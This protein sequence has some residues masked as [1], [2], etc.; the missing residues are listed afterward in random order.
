MMCQDEVLPVVET[1]TTHNPFL[2]FLAPSR[3]ILER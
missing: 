1:E 2:F 3:I